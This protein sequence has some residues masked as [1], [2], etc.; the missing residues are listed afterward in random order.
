MLYCILCLNVNFLMF[1]ASEARNHLLQFNTSDYDYN[2]KDIEFMLYTTILDQ[3]RIYGMIE[4]MLHYP[5]TL[6]N[7]N[8]YQICF[9]SQE[10]LISE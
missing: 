10:K 9:D 1:L 5:P 3:Y 6:L 7:Q 8:I 4:P 2:E